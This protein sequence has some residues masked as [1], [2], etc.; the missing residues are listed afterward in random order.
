MADPRSECYRPPLF[1]EPEPSPSDVFLAGL[2]ESERRA[3]ESRARQGR[4]RA[5][6]QVLP[7]A[8]DAFVRGIVREVVG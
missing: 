8:L 2:R 6:V 5:Q 4:Q 7:D 1:H 3:A